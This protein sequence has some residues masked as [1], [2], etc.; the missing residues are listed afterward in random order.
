VA[1]RVRGPRVI[2]TELA[3]V[4][5]PGR[6]LYC[7]SPLPA[8]PSG[9]KA[10]EGCISGSSFQRGFG[11]DGDVAAVPSSGAINGRRRRSGVDG[12]IHLPYVEWRFRISAWPYGAHFRKASIVEPGHRGR[13]A[14]GPDISIIDDRV[15]S[16]LVH[17][18]ARRQSPQTAIWLAQN[19]RPVRRT[20]VPVVEGPGRRAGW[21]PAECLP[22]CRLRWLIVAVF[23]VLA[24]SRA[25]G[26]EGGNEVDRIEETTPATAVVPGPVSRNV[27]V[28]DGQRIHRLR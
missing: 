17:P 13:R 19:Y 20:V 21:F 14:R 28:V 1:S 12:P 16:S 15:D 18:G 7:L 26:R 4:L 9:G 10:P 24:V 6:W 27:P 5:T 2:L 11:G 3:L 25:V 23:L 22:S 8:L